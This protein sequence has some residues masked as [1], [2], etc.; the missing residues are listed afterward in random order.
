[1][2]HG[3]T[4]PDLPLSDEAKAQLVS[5]VLPSG[6]A[7]MFDF[8]QHGKS[9]NKNYPSPSGNEIGEPTYSGVIA[10]YPEDPDAVLSDSGI[11]HF[12]KLDGNFSS[13]TEV[14][15]GLGDRLQAFYRPPQSNVPREAY[16]FRVQDSYIHHKPYDGRGVEILFLSSY[17]EAVQLD[18]YGNLYSYYNAGY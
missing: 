9:I 16:T 18:K 1:M 2:T 4:N 14:P 11:F 7:N 13:D 6:E 5:G 8:S 15:S 17:D 3:W 12:H 10:S